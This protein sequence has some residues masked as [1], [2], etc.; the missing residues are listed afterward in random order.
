MQQYVWLFVLQG[1]CLAVLQSAL[2]WAIAGERTRLALVA[3]FALAAEVLL[4]LFVAS[5]LAQFVTVAA[6]TAAVTMVVVCAVVLFGDRISRR[7]V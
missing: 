1:A 6:V 2:L 3:W 5:T 7:Q 4:L